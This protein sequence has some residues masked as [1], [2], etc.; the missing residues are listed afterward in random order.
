[1]EPTQNVER[2]RTWEFQCD[3]CYICSTIRFDWIQCSSIENLQLRKFPHRQENIKIDRSDRCARK[4]CF[5]F[6]KW[7]ENEGKTRHLF[8]HYHK[9]NNKW[10]C[11]A[12]LR[13][14]Q[15]YKTNFRCFFFFLRK[16]LRFNPFVLNQFM[17]RCLV[18]A[19]KFMI[20]FC[21]VFFIFG[22]KKF[23]VGCHIICTTSSIFDFRIL[24]STETKN[25]IILVENV[26]FRVSHLATIY[27]H[28]VGRLIFTWLIIS[29]NWI[30]NVLFSYCFFSRVL[31]PPGGGS[32]DIFGAGSGNQAPRNANRTHNMTSTIF[33]AADPR[34]TN[35][36]GNSNGNGHAN[37]EC[38]W[39]S[40]LPET[41]F[42]WFSFLFWVCS[43]YFACL[44]NFM[45]CNFWRK[46]QYE[47]KRCDSL[48][49]VTTLL[50]SLCF[51]FFFS[52]L[53]FFFQFQLTFKDR[54]DTFSSVFV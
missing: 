43:L 27:N 41:M 20:L 53:F 5:Y 24:R 47:F 2:Q 32:S 14:M 25:S 9:S 21:F 37:G 38:N 1:M 6:R 4:M 17:F 28:I 51:H 52:L 29:R 22:K 40:M 16:Q 33:G 11:L 7:N 39:F 36:N 19:S 26:N 50:S 10:R 23:V 46:K 35:V 49:I 15:I 12:V 44:L 31:K 18:D 54:T 3:F 30:N 42:L 45:L 13:V 8:M 34:G 48:N